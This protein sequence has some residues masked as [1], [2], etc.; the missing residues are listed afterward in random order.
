[1][2]NTVVTNCTARGTGDD[3]FALWPAPSSGN[4]TPANNVITHCTGQLP[5]LANGGAIYGG[6]NNRIEDSLF[7]DFPYG[8]GIL[9]STT[10]PVSFAFSGTNIA[11]RCD[12]I[13]CGGY[14]Y[15]YGWRS[16]V[17]IV[18]DNYSGI[19]GV[20][21]SNLNIIDS[22]SSG[23][24]ILGGAGPL[25]NATATSVNVANYNLKNI[26]GQHAWWARCLNGCA[27]GGLTVSN[28]VVPDYQNDSSTFTF[29]FISNIV[30]VTVQ[31]NLP[32]AVFLVDGATCTNA[33]TFNWPP[34]SSHSLAALSPQS[35][36]A[37]TQ[38]VWS[39]WSD[40]GAMS[41]L[42]SPVSG[43]NFTANFITQYYL[44]LTAGL[45][46]GVSPAS[47]W[48]NGGLP[49][50][51][52]ATPSNG[53]AFSSWTGVGSGSYSGRTNPAPITLN[54]PIT[55]DA[56][57]LPPTHSITGLSVNVSNGVLVTY[58]TQPG[59]PY[60]VEST[61]NLAPPA[62]GALP[63][64]TTNPAGNSATFIDTNPF[65]GRQR[66]YRTVSP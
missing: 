4:Y 24:S 42:A 50:N 3:C 1:M 27:I 57:F 15:G 52:S 62:W 21:L 28:S 18:M 10:F 2:Q 13:R 61:T 38:Y 54:G 59:F 34:G 22:I 36:G 16:A 51:I 65:T 14:D 29:Y 41:H 53:F 39:S 30:P 58:D 49:L 26:A 31:A 64:S 11:Q 47:L 45:G 5:F 7:E 8:C 66:F 9:F 6:A 37:G 35:A 60:H 48:T 33:N 55:E 43:T 20:N 46:G 56:A 12:L 17:Q 23:F 25:T 19:S 63:D 32:G 44:A 40:G